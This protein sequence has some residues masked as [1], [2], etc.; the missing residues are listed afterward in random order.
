LTSED[1]KVSVSSIKGKSRLKLNQKKKCIMRHIYKTNCDAYRVQISV[2]SKENPNGKFSRNTRSEKD[3]LWLCELA[4]L[5]IN[6]PASVD[7]LIHW[8]NYAYMFEHGICNSHE[9][10]V[11]TLCKEMSELTSRGLIRLNEFYNL[12][13]IIPVFFPVM[14]HFIESLDYAQLAQ[15]DKEKKKREVTLTKVGANVSTTKKTLVPTLQLPTHNQS[16]ESNISAASLK[17]IP[18]FAFETTSFSS[19]DQKQAPDSARSLEV[20]KES[21]RRRVPSSNRSHQSPRSVE[22]LKQKESV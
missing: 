14:R 13:S 2:G 3:A 12:Q 15:S 16:P 17:N 10:Y 20:I 18:I 4:I 6:S 22:V 21:K 9:E 7:Y 5:F 19:S 1:K 8:G 11:N